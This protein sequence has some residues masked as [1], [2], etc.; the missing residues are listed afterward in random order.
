MDAHAHLHTSNSA[1]AHSL[2]EVTRTYG[3]ARACTCGQEAN[4]LARPRASLENAHSFISPT[5]APHSLALDLSLALALTLAPSLPPAPTHFLSPPAHPTLLSSTF[6]PNPDR[7]RHQKG[8]SKGKRTRKDIGREGKKEREKRSVNGKRQ[9]RKKG[10]ER[11]HARTQTQTLTQKQ[12]HAW[13]THR[14]R[15]STRAREGEKER[16]SD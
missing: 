9:E 6:M 7:R 12:I 4:A 14:D 16:A 15:A 10:T 13:H 8:A 1:R 11:G 5:L 2:G 3:N